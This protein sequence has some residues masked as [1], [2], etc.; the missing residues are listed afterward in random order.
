MN[1]YFTVLKK[2]AVF[3][4]RA[5]RKEFWMFTL[6]NVLISIV[7]G[8][9]DVIAF[10]EPDNLLSVGFLSGL[11]SLFVFIPSLAVWVRRLHD[12]DKSAWTLLIALVP[13]LGAIYLL[14]LMCT[15]GNEGPNDYG[16]DPKGYDGLQP[17]FA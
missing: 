17:D 6:F 7:L 11:Y 5:R 8:W 9:V 16:Q 2:Y 13:I 10:G 14:V 15:N 1:W 4:G 3:S 12:L